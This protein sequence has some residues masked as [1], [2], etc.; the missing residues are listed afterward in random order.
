MD[1]RTLKSEHNGT[2][3]ELPDLQ[4]YDLI[5]SKI[6]FSAHVQ[7]MDGFP[8]DEPSYAALRTNVLDTMPAARHVA[9][10]LDCPVFLAHSRVNIRGRSDLQHWSKRCKVF[11]EIE[12]P[13]LMS[14]HAAGHL[15]VISFTP[16]PQIIS[17]ILCELDSY[18]AGHRNQF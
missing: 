8:R 11:F 9:L 14:L 6:D 15:C 4:F 3:S 5:I 13:F 10:L 17:S 18:K 16:N 2:D 1:G 12:F 7:I